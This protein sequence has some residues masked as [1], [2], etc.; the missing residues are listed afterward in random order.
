M[1]VNGVDVM[2]FVLSVRCLVVLL[3]VC[4]VI[5]MIM[6]TFLFQRGQHDAMCM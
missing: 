1:Y 2:M 6:S 4:V 5:Y 3:L